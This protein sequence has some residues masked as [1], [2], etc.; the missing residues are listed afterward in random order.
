MLFGKIFSLTGRQKNRLFSHQKFG[1]PPVMFKLQKD[2][3][4]RNSFFTIFIFACGLLLIPFTA[5]CSAIV[6]EMTEDDALKAI[7]Q[8]TKDGKLPPESSILEIENRYSN[9]RTGALAKLLRARIRFE[10]K[11]FDNAAQIL[12]SNVFR[13][14]TELGDYALWLRG[15]A[16]Q[17]TGKHAEAMSVFSALIKE[18]P[19][20]IRSREAR[21][22]WTNS[23][24]QSGQAAQVSNFLK[25]LTD[26]NQPDA[27]L[28]AAKAYEAQG[29]QANAA[30]LYRKVYFYAAG[31]DAAKEAE[32]KLSAFGQS[33]APQTPEE[34]QTRAE[35][36]YNAKKYPEA[37]AA[38]GNLIANFPA[39]ATPAVHLKRLM[40]FINQRLWSEAQSAF[41]SIPQSAAEKQDGY[42]HLAGGY[43]RARQWA[44]ARATIEE[45]RRAFPKSDLTP[46][47]LVDVGMAA[48]DAKNKPDESYF[49]KT[50]V[51][52]YPN[53]VEV[54]GA[55][56]ELAWL[57][58]ENSN[59]AQSSQMLVEHLARYVDK[60]TTNRGKAGYWAARDSERAGK[61]PEACALYDGI[62]HRYAANWY[63]Y[64]ASQ[65]L[66]TLRGQ[67]KCKTAPNFPAGS[68]VP[69]AIEN[70]KLITVAPENAT[71]KELERAEKSEE[72]GT[73]GLF[74]W[75]IEELQEAQKSAPNSP[76]INLAL[77]KYHRFKGD[78]VSALLALAKSYPD[79]SQMNP[80]EM[81]TE[82]WDIFYPLT[83]WKEIKYWAGQRNL[84][85]F[86]VAGLIRQESVFNPRAKSGANAYGLMQL[87]VPTARMMAKKYGTRA[88]VDGNTLFQPSLNIELG[89][90]YM[91]D[92]LA[93]YGR[94]EYMAVAYNA[95]PGRVVQWRNS[96]PFEIDE[97]VEAI[98]F[99]ETR[100]Y[101]Q[102]VIR[103]AA[104][105]RR[106]YD[107]NGKFK[108][109]V[110]TRAL[111]AEID[112]QPREQFAR[113]FPEVQLGEKGISE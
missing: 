71:A 84:D 2:R 37:Q 59:F 78:N 11:D 81:G 40:T 73:V 53:A 109:N 112:T 39:S 113:E 93:N 26:K 92:Q 89:T 111:R 77:A 57:E 103:N 101:V 16:L 91:R 24:L 62:M 41:N 64:L 29:N 105:Y 106:L 10:N 38:Y 82:E 36:L 22:L 96:L 95:G 54:A 56:F 4:Y 9:T 33:L 99:R 20:S 52:A 7:R 45:M 76:K 1:V 51:A 72:L 60:D 23:A 27:L 3:F 8:L 110:G 21:L 75:A 67:G 87:L 35:K 68:L 65:K 42:Y 18:F 63:G 13:D 90:A 28:L 66:T 30:A 97:Y 79:Y 98:P 12:N 100:G 88:P 55:Q 58:H 49:L 19:N 25:E 74:D 48:R 104:Q 31:S 5:S 69:K 108:P 83:N 50:A 43:A 61:I 47:A 102:G 80:E 70:L 94:I 6:R 86:Q 85:A 34:I 17:Q 44:Q 15:R 107:E 32:T 14:K 46:K